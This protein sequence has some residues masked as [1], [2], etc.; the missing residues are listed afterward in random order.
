MLRKTLVLTVA[1]AALALVMAS[2]DN[3]PQQNRSVLSIE[4]LNENV[5]PVV[6]DVLTN[7]SVFPDAVTVVFQNR[8]YSQLITTA[9]D[10]PYGD[11]EIYKYR[12][13]WESTDGSTPALPMYEADMGLTVPS[14]KS[15]GASVII[16]TW[17]NKANPPLDALVGANQEAR[18]NAKITFFGHETGTGRETTIQAQIGVIF[19]DFADP[20]P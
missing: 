17:E 10:R 7:G 1:L 3:D 5:A 19:A 9:P 8:P 2:C 16:V 13:E 4:S 20:A 11:F 14:F 15:A 12:V 18:M 6:S